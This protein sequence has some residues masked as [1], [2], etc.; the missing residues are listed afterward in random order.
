MVDLNKYPWI[1]KDFDGI[2]GFLLTEE[3]LIITF[4]KKVKPKTDRWAS[5]NMNLTNVTALINGRAERYSLKELYHIHR[6]YE[7]KNQR[8]QRL[9]KFKP[10]TSKSLMR[11]YSSRERN[12]AGGFTH[13]L[14]TEV[15]GKLKE[16]N[17]GAIM[18]GLKGI[19]QK[20][21]N[22]S[23]EQ[24]RKL[25]KWNARIFQFMLEYKLK[26]LELSVKYVNPRNSSRTCPLRSGRIAS[27]GLMKCGKC[28][29]ALDRDIVAALNLQM[30]GEGFPQRALN[31]LIE[32]EG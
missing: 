7:V 11:K 20:I 5:F 15:V 12:R 18:E 32:G 19:K 17:S 2:G 24:N 6:V 30:R 26:W 4:K 25:S 31:E 14:T 23:K 8:I 9:P 28:K 16:S 10:K 13:K 21:L 29:L 3:E 1:S 22:R 27:Y